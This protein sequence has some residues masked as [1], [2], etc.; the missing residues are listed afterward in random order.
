MRLPDLPTVLGS[1]GWGDAVHGGRL[2]GG[3]RIWVQYRGDGLDAVDQA[4]PGADHDA[5]GVDRPDRHAGERLGCGLSLLDRAGQ[6]VAAG[7]DD[8]E[9]GCGRGDGRP[10]RRD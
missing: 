5:V 8:D 7:R 9:V 3:Y 2:W 4:G 10:A 1:A 6:V